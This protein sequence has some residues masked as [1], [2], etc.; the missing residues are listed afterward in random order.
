MFQKVERQAAIGIELA[1]SL[2]L[3]PHPHQLRAELLTLAHTPGASAAGE[4]EL[5]TLAHTPG[6][7][8]AESPLRVRFH[9]LAT[10][11]LVSPHPALP[12]E[13]WAGR[14]RCGI[15]DRGDPRVLSDAAPCPRSRSGVP[16][17][18]SG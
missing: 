5:L 18:R 12:T 13:E 16:P 4:A 7:L 9:Q 15:P 11:E 10:A 17:W 3:P 1:D 2:A 8:A 6:A 14:T